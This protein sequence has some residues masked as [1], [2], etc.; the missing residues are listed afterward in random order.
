M[1]GKLNISHEGDV[2]RAAV[3]GYLDSEIANTLLC[4]FQKALDDSKIVFCLDFTSMEMINSSALSC[5]LDMVSEG[6]ANELLQFFFVGI[7]Q[8][9]RLGFFAIGLLN[10]VEELA[11]MNEFDELTMISKRPV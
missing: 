6:V 7:P 1:A 11:N 5:L 2:F 4:E 10:Y 9:C 8:S 3:I